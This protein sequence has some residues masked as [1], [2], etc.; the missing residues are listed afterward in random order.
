MAQGPHLIFDKSSLQILT[1]DQAA[2]LD[3]FYT[4]NI[5][6]VF[7]VE[8]LADLEKTMVRMKSTPEQLVGALAVKTPDMQP[9]SNVFHLELIQGEILGEFDLRTIF[10][11]PCI[12]GGEKVELG[13]SKG[14]VFRRTEEEEALRRW[15]KKEFLGVEREIAKVWRQSI[16]QIDFDDMVR[17]VRDRIGP[18]R[19]PASL[20]DARSLTDTIIDNLDQ[21][22]LLRLG[23]EFLRL[24]ID[25]VEP[26]VQG[27]IMT[28]RLRLRQ[29]LPYF[30][31]VL[32]INIFFCLVLP[33]Q[34]L[35]GVKQSHQID[36][37]YLCYLP[38]CSVFTSRDK[39]HVQ[40]AKLFLA[41]SQTFVHGDELQNDL[42]KLVERYAKLPQEVLD[43]G[44]FSFA[45]HPPDDEAFLTTR[46]W[47]QYCPFWKSG[48]AGIP[49]S[50]LDPELRKMLQA[51]EEARPDRHE[52]SFE[53]LDHVTFTRN[54]AVKKGIF[55]RFPKNSIAEGEQEKEMR[56]EY[57]DC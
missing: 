4:S 45:G 15:K 31:F 54:V 30:T 11:R 39:F 34:L 42:Q 49:A 13:E 25:A 46:L 53:N 8:C 41:P 2:M 29:H 9:S 18:W 47:N 19:K 7:F 43:G 12:R 51:K 56:F 10:H 6:P 26:A 1:D 48:E 52:S 5:V 22:W 36:L 17:I 20:E 14:I 21:V 44:I 32:S 50:Q 35:S 40:V 27:W 55:Y 57:R 33:T 3:N 16:S 37:A 23:L 38:F 24:P 28:R